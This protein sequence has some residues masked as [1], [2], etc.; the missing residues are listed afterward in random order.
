MPDKTQTSNNPGKTQANRG[1]S[2]IGDAANQRNPTTAPQPGVGTGVFTS[3]VPN[4]PVTSGY[5]SRTHPV[6]GKRGQHHNGIDLAAAQGTPQVAPDGGVVTFAGPAGKAGNVVVIQHPGGVVTRL[7]HTDEIFVKPGQ[8]VAKGQV[9][10]TTGSTG[11]STGPHGHW[12]VLLGNISVNNNPLGRNLRSVDPSQYLRNGD[13]S[14][15]MSPQPTRSKEGNQEK[16]S[17]TTSVQ[18][19]GNASQTTEMQQP[20]VSNNDK[21]PVNPQQIATA[22]NMSIVQRKYEAILSELLSR[23]VLPASLPESIAK[24]AVKTEP[25]GAAAI[26]GCIP[27]MTPSGADKLVG[28]VNQQQQVATV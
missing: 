5:G 6:T 2:T 3:P 7:F 19:N 10:A 14:R 23:G 13:Y 15:I 21:A 28:Q 1:I 8:L 24:V 17:A 25:Q 16:A 4:A 20:K 9:V 22:I 12:E 26:V 27:G 11:T 18:Q